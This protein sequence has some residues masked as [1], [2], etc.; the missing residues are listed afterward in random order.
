MAAAE[1]LYLFAVQEL[2]VASGRCVFLP[3]IPVYKV[4]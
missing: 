3:C 4:V 2:A 1:A